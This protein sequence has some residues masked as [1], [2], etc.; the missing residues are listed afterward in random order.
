MRAVAG[1]EVIN[2]PYFHPRNY[3][4]LTDCR[5]CIKQLRVVVT[6]TRRKLSAAWTLG[7]PLLFLPGVK[8]KFR[9]WRG[10]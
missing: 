6:G 3:F 2:L 1:Q 10:G 8:V 5:V 7:P 4:L 9:L